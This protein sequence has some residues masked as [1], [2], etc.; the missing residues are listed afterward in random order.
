MRATDESSAAS[1]DEQSPD[2]TEK[3]SAHR[4]SPGRVVFTEDGN[5]DAWIATDL[6]VSL[7]R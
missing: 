5:T 1:T 6:T 4:S 3:V 2:S 7:E